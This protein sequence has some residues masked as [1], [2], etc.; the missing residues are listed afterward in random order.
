MTRTLFSTRDVMEM[1]GASLRQ[2]NR[3]GHKGII[4]PAR[5]SPLGTYGAGYSWGWSASDVVK[6][7]ELLRMLRDG[8]TFQK[9]AELIQAGK[10]ATLAVAP[11]D[12]DAHNPAGPPEPA[13]NG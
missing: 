4:P 11:I 7:S 10:T 5:P 8:V 9:A 3:W 13:Q 2:L 1:T 12:L 6:V